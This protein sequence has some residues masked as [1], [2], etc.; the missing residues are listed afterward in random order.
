MPP[1]TPS[2]TNVE[3][4]LVNAGV[5][6]T[7]FA[8]NQSSTKPASYYLAGGFAADG[9]ASGAS[10]STNAPPSTTTP[11][12]SYVPTTGLETWLNEREEWLNRKNQEYLDDMGKAGRNYDSIIQKLIS[13]FSSIPNTMRVGVGG[14]A[15]LTIAAPGAVS[16]ATLLDSLAQNA[17]ANAMNVPY[18]EW[19][20]AQQNPLHTGRTSFI[21][22]LAGPTMQTEGMR[23]GTPSTMETGSLKISPSTAAQVQEWIDLWDKFTGNTGY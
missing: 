23:Y 3:Q 7:A 16:R 6:T 13:D 5:P 10:S 17:Y 2:R 22:Y 20:W 9:Q 19:S 11:S 8:T 15:P 14:S 1:I 12:S 18:N 4:E 21:D